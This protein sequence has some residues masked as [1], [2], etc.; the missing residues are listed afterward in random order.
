M[1]VPVKEAGH[2]L[3]GDLFFVQRTEHQRGG[4]RVLQLLNSIEIVSEHARRSHDERMRQFHSQVCSCE[5]HGFF[6]P[7]PPASAS[8][9]PAA[10]VASSW[11][12]GRVICASC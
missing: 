4:A 11:P 5:I 12:Y 3:A 9:F 2:L 10:A 1:S 8:P 6:S 7:L